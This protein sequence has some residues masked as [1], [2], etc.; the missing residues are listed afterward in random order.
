MP[1]TVPD[2]APA[3][4]IIGAGGHGRAVLDIVRAEGKL[5]PVGFLDADT[6][7]NIVA[8]LPVLGR[9]NLL[10]KLIREDINHALPAVGDNKARQNLL[11][12]VLAEGAVVPS[13]VH[14]MAWVSPDAK[15]G[16]GVVVGPQAAVCHAASI[17]DGA[18]INTAAVVEHDCQIGDCAHLA[19]TAALAGRVTVGARAFVG[20]GAKIIQCVHIGD[21]ALIGAGAVVL[22]DLA[23]NARVAGVPARP[24][25]P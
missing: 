17:G 20:M 4:V 10:G 5:R 18:I 1:D 19:P 15:L 22:R 14:P 9:P 13:V 11:A 21:D 7:L 8:G 25:A 3:V 24:L 16:R 12:D 6:T 23:N 2:N